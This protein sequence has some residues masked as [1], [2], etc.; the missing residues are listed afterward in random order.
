[1]YKLRI[2]ERNQYCT[3]L[4]TKGGGNN[5]TITFRYKKNY[6]PVCLAIRDHLE[7]QP[8]LLYQL[9]FCAYILLP[10][11]KCKHLE[12][13]SWV[14]CLPKSTPYPLPPSEGLFPEKVQSRR[15]AGLSVVMSSLRFEFST[16][17]F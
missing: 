5:L 8:A 7:I 10:L 6:L 14:L 17:K 11:L 12:S 4:K 13:R 9:S 2:S 15:S 1:M 3:F 16:F